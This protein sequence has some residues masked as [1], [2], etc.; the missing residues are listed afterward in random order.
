M[1]LHF[2]KFI[3]WNE[4]C[5]IFIQISIKL[6]RKAPS[7]QWHAN[8]CSD[9]GLLLTKWQDINYLNQLRPRVTPAS[10]IQWIITHWPNVIGPS[11]YS[12]IVYTTNIYLAT[13]LGQYSITT[14]SA[15]NHN[16]CRSCG[17]FVL[18]GLNFNSQ[19]IQVRYCPLYSSGLLH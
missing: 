19:W 18:F 15:Y 1:Q 9:N 8:I 7:N 16:I 13:C 5:C 10:I 17:S 14:Q 6:G 12:W 4:N 11:W 2:S 3:F